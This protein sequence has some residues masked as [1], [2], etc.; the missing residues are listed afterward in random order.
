M[1]G[2]CDGRCVPA[3]GYT[4]PYYAHEEYY[5]SPAHASP[6]NAPRNA[7][8][9][10]ARA[11]LSPARARAAHPHDRQCPAAHMRHPPRAVLLALAGLA[12]L[13]LS[14]LT[15][16]FFPLARF[17]PSA[18]ARNW[19]WPA[20]PLADDTLL[21]ALKSSGGDPTRVCEELGQ[22]LAPPSAHAQGG[23]GQ[24]ARRGKHVLDK[25]LEEVRATV[26]R[27]SG[28][29]ARDW[30][31]WLGWNNMRYIIETGLNHALLL[32]RTLVLPS[33]V[34]ARDCEFPHEVCSAFEHRV[35]RAESG[36][37]EWRNLPAE[38]QDGWRIPIQLMFDLRSPAPAD[39][40]QDQDQGQGQGQERYAVIT[41]AQFLLMH[42]LSAAL[43]TP[44]G[45]WDSAAYLARAPGAEQLTLHRIDPGQYQP[46]GHTV[47]D[48]LPRKPELAEGEELNDGLRQRLHALT[49]GGG[50]AD[51]GVVRHVVQQFLPD[52]DGLDDDEDDALVGL[53]A[54]YDIGPVY[55]FRGTQQFLTKLVTGG[56]RAF[57]RREYMRGWADMYA[58][59]REDV[60]WLPGEHHNGW[61]PGSMRF[62]SLAARTQYQSLV[63]R[64]MIFPPGVEEV[65]EHIA[66]RMRERV[67]G[68]MW[69]AIHM[70]R[71]DFV[72]LGW[73]IAGANAFDSHLRRVQQQLAHGRRMLNE[74]AEKRWEDFQLADV[75]GAEPWEE[76]VG[77][78]PPRDNDPFYVATDEKDPSNL[79]KLRAAGGVL[80]SDIVTPDD[81]RLLGPPSVLT[82]FMGL[83]EQSVMVRAAFWAGHS[84]SSVSGT[85]ANQR[86][87]RGCDT[88]TT[89]LE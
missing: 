27:T 72:R 71:G 32:N 65:G 39:P 48:R 13:L 60:L 3:G 70:R 29:Y 89:A 62:T 44:N 6:P 43:E 23:E 79:D 58:G 19:G 36:S 88:R 61:P 67:E 69:M 46:Q 2:G 56:E 85:V 74:R 84:I 7:P 86:G 75:A 78:Q 47:V 38:D 49:A 59:V 41:T 40:D 81:R 54:A 33:F 22:A 18:T 28:Y 9:P 21:G 80:I 10:P 64:D 15:L 30:S 76:F 5:K 20:P 17:S 12:L 34:Y 45:Q 51:W 82:D 26:A 14:L 11:R 55:T 53:L 63:V 83:V 50:H 35:N 77:A 16:H 52:A 87:R 1:L 42:G 57:M 24:R 73:T 37:E 8:T 68:R 4:R 25:T 66:R 31:L